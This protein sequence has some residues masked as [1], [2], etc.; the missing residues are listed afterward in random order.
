VK[1]IGTEFIS[2]NTNVKPLD[3]AR[4]RRALSLAIDR[5]KLKEKNISNFPTA[6]LVPEIKGYENAKGADFDPNQARKLLAE[7]GFPNGAGFPEIEYIY[8]TTEKNRDTAQFVQEQWQKELGVRVKLNNMEFKQFLQKR[9][10]L[11]FQGVARN[12]WIGDYPDAHSFLGGLG[13]FVTGW[14]DKKFDELIA[15]SNAE[16]DESKRRQFLREAEGYLLEQ[17][18]VIP[19]FISANAMLVKP[20]VKNLAPNALDFINWRE[21]YIDPNFKATD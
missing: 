5:E 9:K 15:K 12:G 16:P 8:N 11:D 6:S 2:F 3:D 18:P 13:E 17:Q 19:L 20:Y 14:S 4:V 10:A 1:G 7:A 21:V